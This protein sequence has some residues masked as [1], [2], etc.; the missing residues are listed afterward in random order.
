MIRS[1]LF[2][3]FCV[4]ASAQA[5]NVDRCIQHSNLF[6]NDYWEVHLRIDPTV[7]IGPFHDGTE[8]N[9]ALNLALEKDNGLICAPVESSNGSNYQLTKLSTGY[10]MGPLMKKTTCTKMLENSNKSYSCARVSVNETQPEITI[11]DIEGKKTLKKYNFSNEQD[12]YNKIKDL[13]EDD[14]PDQKA[15]ASSAPAKKSATNR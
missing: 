8:C 15:K 1:L 7:R 14:H 6:L 3:T 4:G 5:A 13:Y 9:D 10:H 2:F 11:I 12:C